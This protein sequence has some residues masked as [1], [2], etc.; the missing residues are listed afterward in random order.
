MTLNLASI[1]IASTRRVAA[2]ARWLLALFLVAIAFILT[3]APAM[4]QAVHQY[5]NTTDSSTNGLNENTAPCSNPF[6]RT[7]SVSDSFTVTD[8]QIGVLLAH[9]YRGDLLMWLRAPD[10]TRIQLTS[11]FGT[12]RDNYNV[13]FDDGAGSGIA[14][15]TFNATAT[16][17]TSVPPY[18]NSYQ[19]TASLSGFAGKSSTGTW[20]LE[21]CDQFNQDS[22]TFYQ[23]DL[24]LTQA[25]ANYADLSI[26]KQVSNANPASGS[27]ITYT[28]TVANS[29]SSPNLASGVEVTDLLPIGTTYVSHSGPGSYNSATGLWQV[30]SLAPGANAT[31]TIQATVNATA[32]AVITNIAEVTASSQLDIDSTVANGASNE[33]D[34]DTASL[35]VSGTRTAGTPPVLSC[36]RGSSVFDWDTRS[37]TAGSLFQSYTL[38]NVGTLEFSVSSSGTWVNDPAFGG[39][40]PVLGTANTGG[41]PTTELTLSQYLDFANI[42]QT[43][44]TVLTLD[45]A[46][47]GVQ[48]TVFDIDYA[49][50]DFADKMTVVGTYQGATVY[51]ILTNGLVNY[52]IGNTVIGDGSSGGTQADGNVVVTFTQP[53]DSITIVYGNH[54]T[55]PS[56]PDGQAIS[57]H[58]FT[59]CNPYAD[60]TVAKVSSVISDPVNGTTS[61]RAVPGA[62]VE[63]LITVA[64]NGVSPTNPDSVVITDD[65]PDN[66]KICFDTNGSGQPVVFTD[67]SPSSGLAL[68]YV[69][70]GD[71]SDT[72]EF[73]NDGGASWT[74]IPVPDANGCDASITHFRLTPTGQFQAGSSFTIRTSYRIE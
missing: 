22:G 56:V 1:P 16:P 23:A 57:I 55:A 27:S 58:D 20:T 28:I 9:T 68:G 43:A 24:F 29:P 64:N 74:H 33:D 42:N 11:G 50:N 70:L 32:G 60:I 7:F 41:L 26:S 48:F 25:L 4:A 2:M 14:N 52:V 46:V 8:V 61:P 3:S 69:A 35:T 12:S 6:T 63:Y 5:T 30:G 65:G 44:T 36:P 62:L 59:F 73:S 13:L 38:T 53:V 34:Y 47:P 71:G 19:P 51:P 45:T 54:T 40:T 67:G 49:A 10:G 18:A 39:Q 21:I 15:Y 72:L 31:L 66:A 37:W 17:T